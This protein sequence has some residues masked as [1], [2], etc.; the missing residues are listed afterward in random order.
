MDTAPLHAAESESPPLTIPAELWQAM[1]SGEKALLRR[2]QGVLDVLAL[3]G[4]STLGE[5]RTT[6]GL[7]A[8]ALLHALRVLGG[9]DLVAFG[10]SGADLVIRLIAVPD[11][12]VA[13]VGPDRK[14]RWLFVARPLVPRDIDPAL[15]N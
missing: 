14:R 15:L 7:D 8:E 6:M 2:A 10:P 11:E 4:V 1:P 12:H 3:S 9:M 5:L 13:V